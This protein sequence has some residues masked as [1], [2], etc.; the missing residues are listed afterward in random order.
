MEAFKNLFYLFMP[1]FPDV[2]NDLFHD[3]IRTLPE[4]VAL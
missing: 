1:V 3:W 2:H 4:G